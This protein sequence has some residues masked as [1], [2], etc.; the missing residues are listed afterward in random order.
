[1]AATTH[2]IGSAVLYERCAGETL[3]LDQMAVRMG[4]D[5]D[6]GAR[7]RLRNAVMHLK[8]Q[9]LAVSAS[10]DGRRSGLWEVAPGGIKKMLE[11]LSR[12]SAAERSATLRQVDPE[13][14]W[15]L[16]RG[17]ERKARQQ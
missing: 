10:E 16:V 4:L 13:T 8:A 12:A 3:S 9:G 11:T 7:H 1:M 2:P 17:L 15:W 5:D 6:R 14:R